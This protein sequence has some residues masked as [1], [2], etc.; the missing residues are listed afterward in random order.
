VIAIGADL[1]EERL[2][3]EWLV[4]VLLAVLLSVVK[5]S[6]D[7]EIGRR[8]ALFKADFHKARRG[9]QGWQWRTGTV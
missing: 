6:N 5:R 4:V 8:K 7:A 1:E 3:I 9:T 2:D